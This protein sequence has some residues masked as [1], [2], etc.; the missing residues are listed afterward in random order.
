MSYTSTHGRELHFLNFSFDLCGLTF[1]GLLCRFYCERF[2]GSREA[3]YLTTVVSREVV[4]SFFAH[5]Y[6]PFTL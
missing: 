5:P 3:D 1:R 6:S 4:F 2:A